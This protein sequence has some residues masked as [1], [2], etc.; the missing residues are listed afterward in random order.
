[1][2]NLKP[3]KLTFC[4]VTLKYNCLSWILNET[5]TQEWF[6]TLYLGYL[7]NIGSLSHYSDLSNGDSF[8]QYKTK[9]HLSQYQ[10]HQISFY[11]WLGMS[12]AYS[13]YKF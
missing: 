8:I 11:D 2:W 4:I 3:C 6:Q 10:S 13:G 5:F 9:W 1:M 12:K 7:V